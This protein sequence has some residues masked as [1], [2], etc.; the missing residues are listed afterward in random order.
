MARGHFCVSGHCCKYVKI[1]IAPGHP[2]VYKKSRVTSGH[3]LES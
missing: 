1:K 2:L 3:H